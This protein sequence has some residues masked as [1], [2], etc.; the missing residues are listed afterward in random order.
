MLNNFTNIWIKLFLY[1]FSFRLTYEVLNSMK[2]ILMTKVSVQTEWSLKYVSEHKFLMGKI[3]HSG[4]TI[5]GF[6]ENIPKSGTLRVRS[7]SFLKSRF[8]SWIIPI[9]ENPNFVLILSR[10]WDVPKKSQ[11]CQG[12]VMYF[13]H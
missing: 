9:I 10:F 3:H 7:H 1:F 6:L 4:L 12:W 5:L 8:C 11:I 2:L 13:A